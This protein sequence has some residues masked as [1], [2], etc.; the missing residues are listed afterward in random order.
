MPP[1]PTFAPRVLGR[2]VGDMGMRRICDVCS[3][4]MPDSY[5]GP[6][7]DYNLYPVLNHTL[8]PDDISTVTVINEVCNDCCD[9]VTNAVIKTL[10]ERGFKGISKE[11]EGEVCTVF[12]EKLGMNVPLTIPEP[13]ISNS[14]MF[15]PNYS[16]A[17]TA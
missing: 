14:K 4:V 9:A 8:S 17:T 1:P 12:A 5:R 11:K 2:M 10:R 6:A 15:N 3:V 16:G 7:I 13:V